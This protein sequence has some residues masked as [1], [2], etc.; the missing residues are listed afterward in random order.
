VF[1]YKLSTTTNYLLFDALF[2]RPGNGSLSATNVVLLV[3]A[4]VV[5][6]R[7]KAFSFHNRSSSNFAYRLVTTLSIVA[8]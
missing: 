2:V 4:D 6:T 3:L 7:P 5:S 1:L 8:P